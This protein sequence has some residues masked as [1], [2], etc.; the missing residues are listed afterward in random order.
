M[1][2]SVDLPAAWRQRATVAA[3]AVAATAWLGAG[4]AAAAGLWPAAAVPATSLHE[5][6]SDRPDEVPPGAAGTAEL[7]VAAW[8]GGAEADLS[9]LGPLA[10]GG[11]PASPPEGTRYAARA[12][13]VAAEPAGRDRWRLTVAVQGLRRSGDAYTPDG[14]AWFTVTVDAA[15][16]PPVVTDGPTEHPAAPPPHAGGTTSP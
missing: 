5:Q 12:A 3:I 9:Q 8:L 14:I 4:I 7:V 15:T 6:G 13:T 2:G 10:R 1:N 16:V 11:L